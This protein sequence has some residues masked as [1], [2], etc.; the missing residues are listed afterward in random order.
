M[1][2][3]AYRL[4]ALD[5]SPQDNCAGAVM[6]GNILHDH[7]ARRRSHALMAWE[8]GLARAQEAA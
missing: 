7:A 1:W 6:P 3:M 8:Y 4:S 2:R 5:Q